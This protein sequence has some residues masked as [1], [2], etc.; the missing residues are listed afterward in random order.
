MNFISGNSED[1]IGKYLAQFYEENTG[2]K[3]YMPYSA[4]GVHDG[5][6]LLGVAIF[7][8]YNGSNIELHG[9]GPGCFTKRS[10]KF[11]FNYVFNE[12]ECNILRARPS[13]NNKKAVNM[14][15]K[16]GFKVECRL[17]DY[18]EKNVDA[19]MFKYRK[20]WAKRWINVST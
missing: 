20:N 12:L 18:F 9:Y 8:D 19:L 14:L 11:L 3:L 6:N 4:I 5:A 16:L 2:L 1:E 13:V 17:E 10:I 7:T 15:K